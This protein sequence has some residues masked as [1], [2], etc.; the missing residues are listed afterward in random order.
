MSSNVNGDFLPPPSPIPPIPKKPRLFTPLGHG[1]SRKYSPVP[2]FIAATSQL[3]YHTEPL[4]WYFRSNIH[5]G[6]VHRGLGRLFEEMTVRAQ[7]PETEALI[8]DF[9]QANMRPLVRQ[10]EQELLWEANPLPR[11]ETAGFNDA[12]TYLTTLLKKAYNEANSVS[13]PTPQFRAKN[14]RQSWEYYTQFLDNSYLAFLM[15]TQDEICKLFTNCGHSFS[16]VFYLRYMQVD[17]EVFPHEDTPRDFKVFEM[18]E[19]L[20]T[21]Y[22][23]EV[24]FS[25][26]L[27]FLFL[28]PFFADFRRP[29]VWRLSNGPSINEAGA[30]YPTR[31]TFLVNS[32]MPLSCRLRENTAASAH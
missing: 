1:A 30:L 17:P 19:Y 9:S 15:V 12:L 21:R 26:N 28:C 2:D 14:S 25:V 24:R 11:E 3:L 4:S 32:T 29:S 22:N 8:S 13:K 23:Y 27:V 5:L 20:D 31:A 10:M 18:S 16:T 6:P 7:A